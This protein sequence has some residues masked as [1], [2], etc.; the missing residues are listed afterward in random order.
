MLGTHY[1]KPM[2]W[3]GDKARQAEASLRR[4]YDQTAGAP[5]GAEPD[6][7]V[8]ACLADDLNT[9]G[10]IAALHRLSQHGNLPALRASLALLGLLDGRAPSWVAEPDVDAELKARVD[11]LIAARAQARKAKDFARADALRDGIAA[12]GIVVKDTPHG[13][14]WE[15]TPDF[16]PARLEALE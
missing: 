11:R 3:T 10:A 15:L 5:A 13:A 16:D 9:P 7:Q 2:D 6:P 12:A 1:R 4:W 14:E 8:R